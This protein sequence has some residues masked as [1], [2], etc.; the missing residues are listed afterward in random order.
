MPPRAKPLHPTVGKH[1]RLDSRLDA[2]ITEELRS[3]ISGEIPYGAWRYLIERL[4]RDWLQRRRADPDALRPAPDP[5]TDPLADLMSGT[6]NN[7]S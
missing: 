1:I 5:E 2:A 6:D 4:L 7:R 3:P